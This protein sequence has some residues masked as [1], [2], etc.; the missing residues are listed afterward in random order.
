MDSLLNSILAD[1]FS[2]EDHALLIGEKR[3]LDIMHED[4][5]RPTFIYS[6]DVIRKKITQLR[7]ALPASMRINFAIKSNP[8]R[9]VVNFV[10]Q[11]VDGLDVASGAELQLALD[12]GMPAQH[13][14]F[15][16]PGKTD[17]ELQLAVQQQVRINVESENELDRII[18][19]ARAQALEPQ[20]ALRINPDFELRNSAI[21]MSGG[22]TQF[23]IDSEIAA[24]VID[25]AN[26]SPV[27]LLGL[28][29]Y[30]GSQNLNVDA[31][32]E[33]QQKTFALIEQLAHASNTQFEQVNIGGGFG[34]PY[35]PEDQALDLDLIGAN[36]EQLLA[37]HHQHFPTTQFMTELGRY[38]V[39]ESGVYI[40]RVVDKKISRGKTFIIT[41]G[42]LNHNLRSAAD[43]FRIGKKNNYPVTIAN[44][45]GL[46]TEAASVVGPLCTPLD[47][48]AYESEIPVAEV[49]DYFV[50]F[51]SG[52]YGYSSSPL[53]FLSHPK[54]RQF[55]V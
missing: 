28:H 14:S 19:I 3:F 8:M 22:P 4:P 43:N 29:I 11:H 44:K 40:S 6:K 52:A 53:D 39:G 20:I 36:L 38:I 21:C 16:G 12:S 41:N 34:I 26:Q 42:G 47:V 13:I 1:F 15:A 33:T 17:T 46:S 45:I 49:G 54:P 50:V 10:S 32:I 24:D 37:S 35:Y 7:Q 31:I 5:D 2:V 25:K 27:K 55:L 48:L 18:A 51:Q 30:T 9:E 23:G